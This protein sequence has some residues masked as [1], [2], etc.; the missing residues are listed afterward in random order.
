[1]ITP[2]NY[3]VDGEGKNGEMR[4]EKWVIGPVI[5]LISFMSFSKYKTWKGI[6][7]GHNKIYV[8]YICKHEQRYL[9]RF[10]LGRE[11][12]RDVSF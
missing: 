10:S 12:W 2:E 7:C 8:Y 4:V 1:V 11:Q 9:C 6:V 5:V 3:D